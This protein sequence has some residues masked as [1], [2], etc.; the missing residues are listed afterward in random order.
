[1]IKD[2]SRFFHYLCDN[3]YHSMAYK[4]HKILNYCPIFGSLLFALTITQ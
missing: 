3:L 2:E 1:M 4:D